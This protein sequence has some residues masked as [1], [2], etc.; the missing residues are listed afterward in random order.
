MMTYE[1]Y[2]AVADYPPEWQFSRDN[3]HWCYISRGVSPC[4]GEWL[5]QSAKAT[6]ANPQPA[7]EAITLLDLRKGVDRIIEETIYEA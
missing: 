4:M 5:A 7:R 1:E 3:A 2:A 6:I